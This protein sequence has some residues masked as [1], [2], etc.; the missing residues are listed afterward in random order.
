MAA[1][2]TGDAC[3]DAIASAPGTTVWLSPLTSVTT[4]GMT[5][6]PLVGVAAGSA[7]DDLPTS[8]LPS[9]G[10]GMVS[11]LRSENML[12]PRLVCVLSA[13]LDSAPRVG[14]LE[15]LGVI[16][17]LRS[18]ARTGSLEPDGTVRRG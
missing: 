14:V 11:R 5:I 2:R 3:A 15:R 7:A 1:A 12:E 9:T 10:V 8:G 4:G 18:R 13:L 6:A 17:G 16:V